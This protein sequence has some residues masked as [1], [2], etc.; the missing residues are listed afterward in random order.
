MYCLLV[1]Y[2]LPTSVKILYK[3]GLYSLETVVSRDY[4]G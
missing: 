3:E 4:K 2:L 1:E